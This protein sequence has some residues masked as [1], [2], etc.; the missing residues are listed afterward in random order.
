MRVPLT[1]ADQLERA[2]LVYPERVGVVDEPDPP[3]GGLGTP[4]S[5]SASS[6]SVHS[7]GCSCP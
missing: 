3:G 2:A 5:S 4:V 7:V 1:I 6:V